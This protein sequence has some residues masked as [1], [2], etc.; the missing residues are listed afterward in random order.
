MDIVQIIGS[1]GFPIVCC[2]VLFK[3]NQDLIASHKQ[4]MDKITESI[5]NN[6]IA[7]TKLC[8]KIE[9]EVQHGND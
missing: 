3:Q 1:L 7:L 2:M 4:E 8:E 6:T 5:N 9:N